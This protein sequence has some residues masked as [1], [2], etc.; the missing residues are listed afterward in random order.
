MIDDEDV[1]RT[2]PRLELQPKLLFQ[3]RKDRCAVRLKLLVGIGRAADGVKLSE[4]VWDPLQVPIE[5][6]ILSGLVNDDASH[7]NCQTYRERSQRP[8]E[9][10][11]M[12]HRI[13]PA[14]RRSFSGLRTHRHFRWEW[15]TLVDQRVAIQLGSAEFRSERAI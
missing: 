9:T 1:D 11:E 15:T 12:T 10:P 13:K 7:V 3:R 4:L 6:A 8:A 5:R 2:A 14:A